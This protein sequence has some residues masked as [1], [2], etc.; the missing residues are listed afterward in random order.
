MANSNS[1]VKLLNGQVKVEAWDLCVD[2]KDRRVNNTPHRRALVHDYGDRLTLNWGKDYPKG[3]KIQGDTDIDGDLQ[4]NGLLNAKVQKLDGWEF[5]GSPPSIHLVATDLVLINQPL[6]ES[7]RNVALSHVEG[8]K[9]VINRGKGYEGGVEIDGFVNV[10]DNMTIGSPSILP[11][12]K[13]PYVGISSETIK[14][15]N[16]K[17]QSSGPMSHGGPNI[18]ATKYI[19]IDLVHEILELKKEIVDLKKRLKALES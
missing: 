6:E 19:D 17:V 18:T 14:V 5:L 10:K 11:Q 3:V 9:L 2:S 1:D 15:H 13:T 4:V 12:S 7:K 16:V 8:D